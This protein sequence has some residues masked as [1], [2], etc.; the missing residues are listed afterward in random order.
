MTGKVPCPC[1]REALV[2]GGW[3][4]SAPAS[5]TRSCPHRAAPLL[6]RPLPCPPPE[7]IA[8]LHP[9][10]PSTGLRTTPPCLR[11]AEH[12]G[13]DPLPS[14]VCPSPLPPR[15]WM[16]CYMSLEQGRPLKPRASLV[17]LEVPPLGLTRK[18]ARL[19]RAPCR[20]ET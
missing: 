5:V 15:P 6:G 14:G 20:P 13:R 19:S 11:Q 7:V 12:P 3:A 18:P 16:V 2:A 10:L 1:T 8:F 9:A 4:G 17:E